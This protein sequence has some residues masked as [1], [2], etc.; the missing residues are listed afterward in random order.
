MGKDATVFAEE[1]ARQATVKRAE[2]ER[3]TLDTYAFIP[4]PLRRHFKLTRRLHLGNNEPELLTK[5]PRDVTLARYARTARLLYHATPELHET[6]YP[7]EVEALIC[8]QV[9][10]E[11]ALAK[12][13][14]L[15]RE[16]KS[17]TVVQLERQVIGLVDTCLKGLCDVYIALVQPKRTH[18]LYTA[19]SSAS[20]MLRKSL[21]SGKG[22]SF[23]AVDYDEIVVCADIADDDAI[24]CFGPHR[25]GAFAAVP[26]P[27]KL[28]ST[29]SRAVIGILA[30]DAT[31]RAWA[32]HP[33]SMSAADVAAFL[34]SYGL[35]DCVDTFVKHGVDGQALLGLKDLN[36]E[37]TLGI[38]RV[39]TRT[40]LVA[41]IEG[42][43]DG[44]PLHLPD[45][46]V[47]FVDEPETMQFL[48]RV[49]DIA[50]PLLAT[51]RRNEWHRRLLD[52]TKNGACSQYDLY[53]I[54]VQ[55]MLHCVLSVAGLAIWR[56]QVVPTNVLQSSVVVLAACEVPSDR[57]APFV[58]GSEKS[59]KRVPLFKETS[60]SIVRGSVVHVSLA[61]AAREASTYSILWSNQSVEDVS[62]PELERRLPVRPLNTQ[63]FQLQGV[64][65][66]LD[67]HSHDFVV[68]FPN[69]GIKVWVQRFQ[70]EPN[71]TYLVVAT[72]D[73]AADVGE[74]MGFLTTLLPDLE[75]ALHCVRG[76]QR[77]HAQRV[78]ATARLRQL[79]A[80]VALTP[81]P[82]ALR[83]LDDLLHRVANEIEAC[84]PGTRTAVFELQPSGKSLRCTFAFHGAPLLDAT[85]DDDEAVATECL[86]AAAPLVVRSLATVR[87]W[88]SI[89][90]EAL[91]VVLL[92]LRHDDAVV[93][94]LVV[95]DFRRVEKGREDEM[96]PERG[97]LPLLEVAAHGMAAALRLKRRAA[98]I[99]ALGSLVDAD[100]FAAPAQLY[101]AALDCL[102]ASLL[103][104]QKA[105]LVAVRKRDGK[106]AV[107]LDAADTA[108][109][110]V[111]DLSYVEG[112]RA[113]VY[114]LRWSTFQAYHALDD[115]TLALIQQ[116]LTT[117]PSLLRKASDVAGELATFEVLVD[118]PEAVE[119]NKKL[120]SMLDAAYQVVFGNQTLLT[121]LV[122]ALCSA[123]YLVALTVSLPPHFKF[124]AEPKFVDLVSATLSSGLDRLH[125]RYTRVR[126]RAAALDALQRYAQSQA[127]V[128]L[129]PSDERA[130][131][132]RPDLQR[133]A[134]AAL[135]T[136]LGPCNAY[137]G[138]REPA[139]A[140]IAFTAA[141]ASSCMQGKRLVAGKGGVGFRVMA[142]Q[143]PV[144]VTT[145]TDASA[146]R[147]FGPPAAFVLPYVAVPVGAVG[148]LALDD[149]SG[150]GP[151]ETQ[152]EMGVVD[153]VGRI[154]DT[155]AT[156]IVTTRAQTSAFRADLRARA[157]QDALVL[158]DN[159]R[160]TELYAQQ[161][162]VSIVQRAFTGVAVYV[163][164]ADGLCDRFTYSAASATSHM[165][166]RTMDTVRSWTFEC[167]LRQTP[168]VLAHVE[169][170][171]RIHRFDDAQ[172]GI[173][174]AVPIPFVGV[175]AVDTFPGAAGGPY[176][177]T[178]PESGTVACL[179]AVAS[180]LGAHI[181]AKRLHDSTKALGG[182]FQGNATTFRVLYSA[183]AREVAR[184]CPAAVRLEV[185]YIYDALP[186]LAQFTQTSMTHAST[187]ALTA[188]D[189]ALLR[190]VAAP[191]VLPDSRS[192]AVR[193]AMFDPY[194][195]GPP[196]VSTVLVVTRVAGADW[197]YD[198]H[199]LRTL[200]PVVDAAFELASQR[201]AADVARRAALAQLDAIATT[202]EGI[203]SVDA[204]DGLFATFDR[205]LDVVA[206]A[207]GKG[208]D[209]YTAFL[210]PRFTEFAKTDVDGL[211]FRSVSAESLMR[212]VVLE[213][214]DLL[215]F[216][217]LRLQEPIVINHLA[218]QGRLVRACTAR[219]ATR[220][221]AVVP[222]STLGV[223]AGD[224]F[225]PAN[226]NAKNE[227]ERD[228]V[229]FLEAVAAR[230]VAL[231]E[232]THHR[233]SRDRLGAVGPDLAALYAETLAAAHRDVTHLHCAHVL[234]LAPDFTGDLT[235]LAWLKFPNRRP[236]RRH[237][238]YCYE[239]RCR[240]HYVRRLI[241]SDAIRLPM[242]NCPTT[243]DD[244]RSGV[245]APVL[246]ATGLDARGAFPVFAAMLDGSMRTPRIALAVYRKPRRP[247][248]ERDTATLTRLV[249]SVQAAYRAAFTQLVCQSMSVEVFFFAREMLQARDG[250]VAVQAGV[251]HFAVTYSTNEAKAP[252]GPLKKTKK[253]A[254]R[255]AAFAATTAPVAVALI[256]PPVA[257]VASMALAPSTAPTSPVALTP[258]S[259][260]ATRFG[261]PKK[262]PAKTT[263]SM[264]AADAAPTMPPPVLHYEVALRL[265]HAEFAILDVFCAAGFVD[266]DA[267]VH[268][269]VMAEWV[270]AAAATAATFLEKPTGDERTVGH[271]LEAWFTV[272]KAALGVARLAVE[273]DVR[274]LLDAAVADAPTPC[275]PSA[276]TVVTAAL[277]CA[278]VKKELVTSPRVALELFLSKGVAQHLFESDPFDVA[279]KSRVWTGA[280]KCRAFLS[281][282]SLVQLV[283]Q[284]SPTL[285]LLLR[286]TV[287]IVAIAKFLKHDVDAAKAA[288]KHLTDAAI[289][290]QC[291]VRCIRARV[292]TQRRRTQR[293][294]AII[295]QCCARQYLARRTV[296]RRRQARAARR[297]QAWWRR[298]RGPAKPTFSTKKLLDH[299]RA[300]Q[301]RYATDNSAP[302]EDATAWGDL[303]GSTFETFLA[304][305]H[306]K[307]MLA[308][309]ERALAAKMKARLKARN[310]L[311]LEARIVEEV[312]DLFDYYDYTGTGS[313]SRDDTKLVIAKLR[314]PLQID[315]LEDV[316]SM[317]D[318]DK[319]GDVSAEEFTN[320]FQY[321][322]AGLRRRS[323]DCGSLS[324]TDRDW[325][326]QAM[327]RRFLRQK[328]NIHV[329][330]TKDDTR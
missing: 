117:T 35:G 46:P 316:V 56:V 80:A 11:R 238:H 185:W 288:R 259:A 74:A 21:P 98:R 124:A 19:A 113:R 210:E 142:S 264:T 240:Q 294:A 207:L 253:Q 77:R 147:H 317:I 58:H 26:L 66:A 90:A 136:A 246:A 57:T 2:V 149:L 293:R 198:L 76:R 139:L 48:T 180:S 25:C 281:A 197:D 308:R 256:T 103:G 181:R 96:H 213:A 292:E 29:K 151:A 55:A 322:L 305:R 119:W 1:E 13:A 110:P 271:L 163:A 72:F 318:F 85:L 170:D 34:K 14:H 86:A 93:G 61:H 5:N 300:L 287:L 314:I 164:V 320:W 146:L 133:A 118:P 32:C 63:H 244:A 262:L 100:A 125:A 62:W 131:E 23:R 297:L 247:F 255:L 310:E 176:C 153:F 52:A 127:T 260:K 138:L 112:A 144:V 304:G 273:H 84:L 31:R 251:K 54:V 329:A 15:E 278:G 135:A 78:A 114:E 204:F 311:P 285:L 226:F 155:V 22:V 276:A 8:T 236:L 243:L 161:Q 106:P 75:H 230:L 201:A 233:Y 169:K 325:F 326:V 68:P 83:A 44:L 38:H 298:C 241:H 258:P 16:S 189:A 69:H 122:P 225:G 268:R 187:A 249:A 330:R 70:D 177:E 306:G 27:G 148:V 223:L 290:L 107:L 208:T 220:T 212:G 115:H 130:T 263:T 102:K 88:L 50:G 235:V 154:A 183:V 65:Q 261:F 277:L 196:V 59:I 319:S 36:L 17:R 126:C 257:P 79:T 120:R 40:K 18:L 224:S 312:D 242:T 280:F 221:F 178:L 214:D 295:L 313:I 283:P 269:V 99:F 104:V 174:V 89:E 162:C 328:Y 10:F 323:A 205:C 71:F 97:V 272:A 211:V 51:A 175:L 9:S 109:W 43:N 150:Y 254:T 105:R 296:R 157:V 128:S 231:Y 270:Q 116:R 95:Y 60:T 156:G 237:A 94:L 279:S 192:L 190:V 179:E 140:T 7:S 41:L 182:I 12:L 215:S 171:P 219:K 101:K 321:E 92:P 6:L 39:H 73:A 49:A 3:R 193:V 186:P 64:L 121:S 245:A 172:T 173:F 81:S 108:H 265:P 302:P 4:L 141:T 152:P 248:T 123:T 301:A 324:R 145:A 160:H 45:L 24:E 327:A 274:L 132:V 82:D 28:H 266:D 166:G 250:V 206:Q 195:T 129:P 184:N 111:L 87:G 200:Q 309:E 299:V 194:V 286:F 188:D 137:I 234:E 284:L 203:S 227:L 222:L 134:L 165:L 37:F 216:Q 218:K 143:A 232:D 91:P 275:P 42:L 47:P 202:T 67:A 199:V 289:K 159:L 267:G 20:H 167:F 252:R 282:T 228:V 209:V 303:A 53:F 315:E 291:R 30:A 229:M 239:H 217:C 33:G 191:E 168:V 307:A 158:S